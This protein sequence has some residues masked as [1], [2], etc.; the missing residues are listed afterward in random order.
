MQFTIT[1]LLVLTGIC[2]FAMVDHL[3]VALRRPYDH[4]HL[5]FT[6][7]CCSGQVKTDTPLSNHG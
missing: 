4:T 7:V 1:G 3:C 5:L 6:S 2:L